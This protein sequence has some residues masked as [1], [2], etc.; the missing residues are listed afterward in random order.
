MIREQFEGSLLG[1]ALGEDDMGGVR[2]GDY[3]YALES[4]LGLL[5]LTLEAKYYFVVNGHTHHRMVRSFGRVTI[6]N[7]KWI[8]RAN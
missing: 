1:L 6:I 4:N 7:G 5:R 3:G 8:R 2:P